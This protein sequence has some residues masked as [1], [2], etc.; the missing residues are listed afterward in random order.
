MALAY[1]SIINQI[2]SKAAA[3]GL[4]AAVNGH[5]PK[6]SPEKGLTAAVWVDRVMPF[7]AASGL[8]STSVAVTIMLR[9]Y[10]PMITDPQDMIDPTM[11]AATDIL[12]GA[13][14][15]DLD[16]GGT[17]RNVDLLGNTGQVLSAQAGYVD[18]GG[19]IFRIIDINIP[20]ILNDV[21]SQG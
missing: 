9:L 10:T 7:G 17:I 14:T 13:L 4:F 11:I 12:M 15:S 19:T 2:T 3:T 18:I 21:W 5:E 20:C 6:N 8:G 1:Q 16:L